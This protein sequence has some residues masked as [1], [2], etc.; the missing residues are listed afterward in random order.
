M[1]SDQSE[2]S[3][4]KEADGGSVVKDGGGER[5]KKKKCSHTLGPICTYII[6]TYLCIYLFI[7]TCKHFAD[8]DWTA[9]LLRV[10]TAEQMFVI[11]FIGSNI[12]LR[13]SQISLSNL[14]RL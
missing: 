1:S 9:V 10:Q 2:P 7:Y 13:Q 4:E 11:S 12:W 5:K 14:L 3:E 6:L 8:L